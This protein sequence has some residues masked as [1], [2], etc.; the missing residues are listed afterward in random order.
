MRLKQSAVP[1][2]AD[3]RVGLDELVAA[4]SGWQ[5]DQEYRTSVRQQ[6][7]RW[8]AVVADAYHL[9]HRPL[10][11]QSEVIGT[12]NEASKPQEV[13]VCAAGSMPGDLTSYGGPGIPRDTTSSTATPAWDTRSPAGSA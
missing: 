3:A 13:V 6:A 9:G 2:V 1:L 5:A 12:V 8:D 4:L 11:A 7:A 10:P